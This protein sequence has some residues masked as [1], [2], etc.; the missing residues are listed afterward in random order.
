MKYKKVV[1]LGAALAGVVMIA[2]SL[3]F[4]DRSKEVT[5]GVPVKMNVE[6]TIRETGTIRFKNAQILYCEG[7]GKIAIMGKDTG[8]KVKKGELLIQLDDH[9]LQ[10]Q[11]KDADAKIASAKAQLEGVKTG[12]YANRMEQNQLL[13]LE[14]KRQLALATERERQKW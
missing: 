8:D 14:S 9:S 13:I 5:A 10:L 4:L 6:N 7:T 11:L 3:S 2:A 1:I 12:D